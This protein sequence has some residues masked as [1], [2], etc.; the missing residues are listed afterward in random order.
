MTEGLSSRS[1]LPV[2]TIQAEGYLQE[3]NRRFFHPLGLA[4]AIGI[5]RSATM[6]DRVKEVRES[7]ERFTGGEPELSD[8]IEALGKLEGTLRKF[9]SPYA[10]NL[11]DSRDDPEG[12]IFE[13][14]GRGG[15]LTDHD[16]ILKA[17]KVETE[18]RG[19]A[20]DREAAL[21]YVVQ[22]VQHV[23]NPLVDIADAVDR[24]LDSLDQ[25]DAIGQIDR[26]DLVAVVAR[27]VGL[28]T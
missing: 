22:P 23:G 24:Y 11:L 25:T 9:E 17:S 28:S 1:V 10:L 8:E 12:V 19:R 27:A 13:V 26:G 16:S 18:W 6:G 14:E 4:L 2:A 7:I 15:E 3:A 21:G 20:V 5:P